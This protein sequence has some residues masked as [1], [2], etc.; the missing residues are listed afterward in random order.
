MFFLDFAFLN[1]KVHLLSEF[2]PLFKLVNI[3]SVHEKRKKLERESHTC[4]YFV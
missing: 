1:L 4:Q 3:I 2:P